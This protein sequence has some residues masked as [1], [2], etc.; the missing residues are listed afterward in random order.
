[1]M[2]MSNVATL[3]ANALDDKFVETILLSGYSRFPVHEPHDP[4][5][6][7][8]LLLIQK[9]CELSVVFALCSIPVL[10]SSNPACLPFHS[11]LNYL[12]TH[13]KD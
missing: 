6:F 11:T 8:V 1:M 10:S 9:V 5:P 3:S 2:L 4:E 7:I 12:S 13:V